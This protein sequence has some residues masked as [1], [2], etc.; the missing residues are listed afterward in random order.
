R[1]CFQHCSPRS[2][3]QSQRLWRESRQAFRDFGKGPC[4]SHSS[5]R[6]DELCRVDPTAR[7]FAVT[8]S[9]ERRDEF[10]HFEVIMV[11]ITTVACADG[12]DLLVAFYGLPRMDEH[13][14]HMS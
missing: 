1:R 5:M 4:G 9:D 3:F 11:E 12:R 7:V 13:V 14:L 10:A 8:G 2:Q 6:L